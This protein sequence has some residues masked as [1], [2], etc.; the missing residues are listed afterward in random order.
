MYPWDSKECPLTSNL[1]KSELV[2]VWMSMAVFSRFLCVRKM[3]LIPLSCIVSGITRFVWIM[4][5]ML[6]V[7]DLPNKLELREAENSEIDIALDLIQRS[8][9]FWWFFQLKRILW[10]GL[11]L[12]DASTIYS[13][14]S[15]EIDIWSLFESRETS[16]PCPIPTKSLKCI[17]YR[18]IKGF[19]LY[20]I[21][22]SC[23][24]HSVTK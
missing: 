9:L 1:S 14:R 3:I 24:A 11:T 2:L 22:F 16:I 17:T 7:V 10:R 5:L 8:L 20:S 23:N 18:R 15:F 4:A 13:P 21:K 12:T 19:F 6:F